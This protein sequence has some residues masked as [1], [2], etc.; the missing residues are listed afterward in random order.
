MSY[1]VY[2][3]VSTHSRPKAAGI[4]LITGVPG[5]G[6]STHSRPKAAG[7]LFG[8]L[9]ETLPVSTHS[10]PKAAGYAA[11]TAAIPITKFQHT[12]ARR[13]LGRNVCQVDKLTCVSTHSRPKAAGSPERLPWGIFVRFNTQPPEGGWNSGAKPT[14]D[15]SLF[16]HTAARRRLGD[17]RHVAGGQEMF[18][19]TAAR[20]R[21][22]FRIPD[23][24]QQFPFQHTAA[25]RRLVKVRHLVTQG[26]LFQHTAAR[27]RLDLP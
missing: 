10:R 26:R 14:T 17:V 12:A 15:F 20:R 21:L 24:K 13:R 19:H 9:S 16:Q 4:T 7:K 3:R 5:S 1:S 8:L 22:V 6:V 2:M 11:A 23:L 27:R 25:R 18:Q